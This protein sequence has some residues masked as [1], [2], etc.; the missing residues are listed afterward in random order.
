MSAEHVYSIHPS[1]ATAFKVAW[2]HGLQDRCGRAIARPSA[3]TTF[4]L[5]AV[6]CNIE[7][8]V[9]RWARVHGHGD[10]SSSKPDLQAAVLGPKLESGAQP[11]SAH[12]AST[13]DN[14]PAMASGVQRSFG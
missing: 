9:K 6:K 12:G 14:R 11:P 10:H 8:D 4:Y 7:V 1:L 5:I 13:K 2:L 3:K